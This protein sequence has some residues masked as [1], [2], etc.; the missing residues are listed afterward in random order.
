MTALALRGLAARKLRS[1]LTAIAIL[2]GV[3][4]IAGTY[5]LTDQIRNAFDDIQADALE[6]IDVVIT[7]EKAFGS[8]FTEAH[9]DRPERWCGRVARVPGVDGRAGRAVR[10]PGGSWSTARPS[11]PMGAPSFV[12]RRGAG[13][14]QTRSIRSD[15]RQ[16]RAEPARSPSWSRS[17]SDQHLEVGDR[18]GV[19]TRDGVKPVRW[20]ASSRSA[21]AWSSLG[22]A[23]ARRDPGWPASSG[24]Y[25]LE[26]KVSAI[27]AIASTGVTAE[28]LVSRLRAALP[29]RA[30][31]PDRRAERATRRP[32][33]ST[34]ASAASSPRRCW[35]SRA[36]R[37][38]SARSSSSTP[39]RSPSPSAR[40][41]SRCCARS[42]RPAAR[43]SARSLPRHWCSASLASV[44]GIARRCRVRASCWRACSTLSASASRAAAWC[45]SRGR[46]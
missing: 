1:A 32:T 13:A 17:P 20:S 41:S 16:P 6:G 31:G 40:A 9:D 35:P 36:P 23:I 27:E 4:M 26:G 18:V 11:R 14:L 3:A 7:P 44:V 8:S 43:C 24:S 10:R 39:S 38:S 5:V 33:R 28:Q 19:A 42:A 34:T 21:R 45:S 29:R 15:G 25:D 2:L 37:C 22:G 30:Q 46:S 12:D